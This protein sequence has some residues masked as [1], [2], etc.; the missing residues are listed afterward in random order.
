MEKKTTQRIIGM[1][2]VIALVIILLP[3]LFGRN[4]MTT[5]AASTIKAPLPEDQQM[6]ANSTDNQQD[7]TDPKKN[8]LD[9]SSDVA[10]AVNSNVAPAQGTDTI[11]MADATISPQSA[12]SSQSQ[13]TAAPAPALTTT[14]ETQAQPQTPPSADSQAPLKDTTVTPVADS[15]QATSNVITPAIPTPEVK[16]EE[17]VKVDKKEL[18]TTKKLVQKSEKH[19]KSKLISSLKSPVWVVQMGSFKDKANAQRLADKLRSSGFKAFTHQFK[20]AKTGNLSTRVYIGP[21]VQHAS[22]Q[23]L[24]TDVMQQLNLQGYVISY[25][26][27]EL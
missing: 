2:V 3:L 8:S 22:A 11:Q 1:L 27:L 13:V 19:T 17:P 4:D 21:E 18:R 24:S 7:S 10:A 6:A 12:P 15:T 23:K 14:A 16:K 9:I 26:P 20:S 25:N 5:E